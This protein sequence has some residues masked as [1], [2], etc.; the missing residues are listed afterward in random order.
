MQYSHGLNSKASGVIGYYFLVAL[1]GV[2]SDNRVNYTV[3]G[4]HEGSR[5]YPTGPAA[6]APLFD[7]IQSQLHECSWPEHCTPFIEILMLRLGK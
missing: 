3:V 5:R 7:G 2:D 6:N 1:H 4:I